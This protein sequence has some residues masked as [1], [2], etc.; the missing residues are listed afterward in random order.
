MADGGFE[1]PKE[2]TTESTEKSRGIFKTLFYFSVYS[3]SRWFFIWWIFVI[4][5]IA[6]NLR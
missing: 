2:Q 4:A 5:M 1:L 6:V 3:V